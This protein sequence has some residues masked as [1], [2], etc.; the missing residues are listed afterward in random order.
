[1]ELITK[2]MLYVCVQWEHDVYGF[3]V[4]RG[5]VFPDS[6]RLQC[7]TRKFRKIGPLLAWIAENV[8]SV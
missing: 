4:G 7:L 3:A 8:D 5:E 1:M 6:Q 2:L